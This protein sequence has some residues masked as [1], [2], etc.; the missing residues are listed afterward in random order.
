MLR[1]GEGFLRF[2]TTLG[3]KSHRVPLPRQL[4]DKNIYGCFLMLGVSWLSDL[5]FTCQSPHPPVQC[6]YWPCLVWLSTITQ[7]SRLSIFAIKTNS[8]NSAKIMHMN[9]GTVTPRWSPLPSC[10]LNCFWIP[11]VC[12]PLLLLFRG[13]YVRQSVSAKIISNNLRGIP[14]A[15]GCEMIG[16]GEGIPAI[17]KIGAFTFFGDDYFDCERGSSR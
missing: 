12:T 7:R 9:L 5:S 2:F 16:E 14:W 6:E 17:Y 8:A 11:R 3:H 10:D 1:L 15:L 13:C 4:N